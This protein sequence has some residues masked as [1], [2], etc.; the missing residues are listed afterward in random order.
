MG[1]LV[2]FV[3]QVFLECKTKPSFRP[4]RSGEPESIVPD[5][6]WC[7]HSHAPAWKLQV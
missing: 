6:M 4:Q 5:G 7:V 2:V 3:L 1:L